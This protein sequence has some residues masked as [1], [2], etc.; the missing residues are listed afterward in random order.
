MGEYEKTSGE[1]FCGTEDS[2]SRVG[3]APVQG[4]KFVAVHPCWFGGVWREQ[5]KVD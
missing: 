1:Y 3:F 4:D 5:V 2:F